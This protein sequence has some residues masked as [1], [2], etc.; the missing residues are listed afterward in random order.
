MAV[1]LSIGILLDGGEHG[2]C[3]LSIKQT[4]A[5]S[6]ISRAGCRRPDVSRRDLS[7]RLLPRKA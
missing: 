1:V 3:R 5:P 6:P 7:L 4:P 2:M